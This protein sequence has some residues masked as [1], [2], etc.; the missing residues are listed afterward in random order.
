M[1]TTYTDATMG[2]RTIGAR[3]DNA[4]GA[5]TD[6]N[7]EEDRYAALLLG[8]GKLSTDSFEAV[9]GA[10][11][12]LDVIIGGGAV[13]A[14]Y[15]VVAGDN[16]G[17]GKYVVRLEAAT[18]TV[19]IDAADPGLPRID[20]I[21]LVVQ[22]NAY[23]ASARALPRFGYRDGTPGASPSAP[24]PDAA[25]DAEVLLVSIAVRSEEHTSELQSR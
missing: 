21:Y 20:E 11:A 2:A 24:G 7:A 3:T 17:Q 5:V 6:L 1:A 22:D 23:D 9:K 14:D 16:A 18:E 15:Y 4:G 8:E 12:T 19:V 25:W 10:G 13:K